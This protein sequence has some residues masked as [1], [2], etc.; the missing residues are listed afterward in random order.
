MPQER[1]ASGK[2]VQ[3]GVVAVAA[4]IVVASLLFYARRQW[5]A[6]Q[7]GKI[8]AILDKHKALWL[9][10]TAMRAAVEE[11][12]ARPTQA[13]KG[14]NSIG[15]GLSLAQVGAPMRRA[16]ECVSKW[17]AAV[18]QDANAIGVSASMVRRSQP[19]QLGARLLSARWDP[20]AGR[21]RCEWTSQTRAARNRYGRTRRSCYRVRSWR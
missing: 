19:R 1:H 11:S 3:I 7:E 14:G 13:L 15:A 5:E 17:Q 18:L 12:L 16:K 9:R 21:F 4:I 2:H 6:S 8:R 10:C 20:I